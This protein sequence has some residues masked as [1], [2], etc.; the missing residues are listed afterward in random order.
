MNSL[1]SALAKKHILL[2]A[3]RGVSAGNVPCNTVEAYEAAIAFGADIVE[4][5]VSISKDGKLYCFHPGM[6][7]PHLGSDKLIA[8]MTSDEV[9]KLR[10]R[11]FDDAPT[12][13]PVSTFYDVMACLKGRCF[14]NVDK[15]W[16]AMPE[17]S[18]VIRSLGME[19]Q[20][21]VKTSPEEKYFA[22]LERVAPDFMY[23]PIVSD[24][25]TV[26]E[27]LMKRNINLAGAEVLFDSEDKAV[28][29]KEYLDFMHANGLAVWVNPI[30]YDYH[31]VISAHH[32][33]DVAIAGDPDA[34]WGWL[35]ERGFDILQ[36]DWLMPADVYLTRKGYRHS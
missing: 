2:A 4:L 18:A 27:K 5:D 20:V 21:I 26:S 22:E 13:Y 31:A 16:T 23:M 29:G 34:G 10:Y 6:E 15:F 17:I 9:E 28:A 8:D 11:N 36:T 35:A 32:T 24:T 19:E 1:I 7:H 33:D 30:V 14:I 25:D 3:H 12:T